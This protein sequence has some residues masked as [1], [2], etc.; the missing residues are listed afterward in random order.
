MK[1]YQGNIQLIG[2]GSW[3]HSSLIGSGVTKIS[4]LEIGNERIR[5]IVVSDYLSN[6]LLINENVKILVHKGF[7]NRILVGIE[8]NNSK[9]KDFVNY[10]SFWAIIK[11]IILGFIIKGIYAMY[12][13]ATSSSFKN[14]SLYSSFDY[15]ETYAQYNKILIVGM[16]ICAILIFFQLKKIY[17]IISF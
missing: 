3:V 9:Y 6:Y 7:F 4:V 12:S 11:S 2:A 14:D 17:D 10:I 1:I 13:I 5:N 8:M 15:S 16:V